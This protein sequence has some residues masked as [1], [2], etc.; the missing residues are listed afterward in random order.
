MKWFRARLLEPSTYGGFAGL[1]MMVG[2]W[3][4]TFWPSW[5]LMIYAAGILFIVQAVMAE[6]GHRP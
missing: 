4:F 5:R 6:R 3:S 1:C 2:V